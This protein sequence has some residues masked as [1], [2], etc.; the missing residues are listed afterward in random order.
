MAALALWGVTEYDDRADPGL[1]GRVAWHPPA[2]AASDYAAM[3]RETRR[4]V[5][6]FASLRWYQVAGDTLPT[7]VCRKGREVWGCYDAM[8][9]TITLAGR[10]VGDSILV[11]HELMHA[12]LQRQDASSHLCRWFT[13]ARQTLWPGQLCEG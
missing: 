12:A 2:W 7:V 3:C 10:R 9:G 6:D 4:C 11:R 8:A 5:L 1:G 13:V